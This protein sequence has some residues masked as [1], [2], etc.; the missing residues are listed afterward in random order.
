MT[1]QQAPV[2]QEAPL[3]VA[4]DPAAS[5]APSPTSC[6]AHTR[7]YR[8]GQ[9]VAEGFPVEQIS[10]H[11]AAPD[12]V[13]WL[14]LEDPGREDLEVVTEELGLH[15]LAVED[16]VNDRQRPKIDTYAEHLFLNTYTVSFDATTGELS[17]GEIA[18]FV[19]PQAL[20]TVRKDPTIDLRPLLSYWDSGREQA[21]SGVAFLLHGLLDHVVDGHFAVV[22][23]LDD[24]V[25]NLEDLLFNGSAD[26]Q[27]RSFTL[28]KSLVSLRRVVLPMREVVNTLVRRDVGVVDERMQ[29]YYQDVYDHVLRAAEWTESLR[30]LVGSVLETNVTL[31][32]NRLNETVRRLTAYAAILA[33]TTAITGFYGQNVP[34]PGSQQRWGFVMSAAIL[35]GAV[36]ALYVFFKKKGYL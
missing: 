11:L 17:T 31:Q 6:A 1:T 10:D 18:A 7:L 29:P 21:G 23:E 30:D 24:A 33:V 35:V 14:D 27:R 22:Q 20:V 3:R 12:T 26:L 8:G 15:R 9:L 32:G 4:T 28:R 25:E 13:V 34:Y 36:V 5:C 16:A 19:T 2:T